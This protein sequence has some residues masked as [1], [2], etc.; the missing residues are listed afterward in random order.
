MFLTVV[1]TTLTLFSNVVTV[2]ALIT[3]CTGMD[4][5]SVWLSPEGNKYLGAMRIG[6]GGL[7][8]WLALK[9]FHVH[10]KAFSDEMKQKYEEMGCKGWWVVTYYFASYILMGVTGWFA[11]ARLGMH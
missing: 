9:F 4:L 10:E 11:G 6:V 1:W 7:F 8:V 5:L 2:C 3:I